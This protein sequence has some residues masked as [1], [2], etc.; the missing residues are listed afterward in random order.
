MILQVFN[1]G[2]ELDL[3][4]DVL[5]SFELK[6]AKLPVHSLFKPIVLSPQPR[7]HGKVLNEFVGSNPNQLLDHLGEMLRIA[8]VL[9]YVI[10]WLLCAA[11]CLEHV[12]HL[13]EKP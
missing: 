10:D 5:S 9:E 8:I 7:S 1:K 3:K 4:L 12:K 6:V 2:L 13:V 11:D